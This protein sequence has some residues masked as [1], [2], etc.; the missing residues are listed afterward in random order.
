MKKRL[1]ALEKGIQTP[2]KAEGTA[3]ERDLFAAYRNRAVEYGIL[4]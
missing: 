1:T 4:S 2:Q 3:M